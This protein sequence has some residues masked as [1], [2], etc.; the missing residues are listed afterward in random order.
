MSPETIENAVDMPPIRVPATW[1]PAPGPRATLVLLPALGTPATYYRPFAEALAERGIQVL[2]PE[3]PGTGHSRPRPSRGVDYGYG[4]L[5]S[6]YLPAL[7]ALAADRGGER[8]L[9][10]AG[11]SL[12]AQ[13]A[14]LSLETGFASPAAVLTLAGGLIHYRH[15]NGVGAA[16]VLGV[17]WLTTLLCGLL[18]YLPGKLVGFGGPQARSLM[19]E[20]SRAIRSGRYPEL[21]AG[22]QQPEPVPALSIYYEGDSFA[23]RRSAAALAARLRGD[24]QC[25]KKAQSGN[26]HAA[27]ARRPG[28]T[29]ACIEAWLESAGRVA[30][31]EAV[32]D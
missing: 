6:R 10:L 24:L 27:W 22:P 11:H 8:P 4:D 7:L 13:L 2:V 28:P 5:V 29:V 26:P 17:A 23:P 12:G 30:A 9:V 32:H 25:L 1:Y 15:W 18:G 20:W 14:M 3:L 16:A 31:K 21:E 19:R